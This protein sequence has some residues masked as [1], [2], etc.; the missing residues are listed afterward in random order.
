MNG[1][2][3]VAPQDGLPAVIEA[4]NALLAHI[5]PEHE[6]LIA[7][8]AGQNGNIPQYDSIHLRIGTLPQYVAV[9]RQHIASQQGTASPLQPLSGEMRSSQYA[10]LL[11]AGFATRTVDKQPNYLAH[12]ALE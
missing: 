11:P 12:H 7:S 6:K 5:D 4:A 10:H 8:F 9:V 2:D 3:P 1:S